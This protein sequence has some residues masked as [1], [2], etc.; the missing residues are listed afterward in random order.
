[1]ENLDLYSLP[2]KYRPKDF[3]EF[4]GNDT[5][6]NNLRDILSRE[7][8]I[9]HAFLFTGP[10]GCGKTTLALIVKEKL[11]CHDYDYTFLNTSNTR[12]I[13]TI[14][15]ISSTMAY[16]PARG[17]TKFYLL[18]ECHK[19]TNEAQNALLNALEHPPYFCYFALCTTNPEK[20][21]PTIKNRCQIFTVKSLPSPQIMKLL[22][23]VCEKEKVDFPANIL[24][25]IAKS[26]AGSC[27]GALKLL[28]QV[29]D[30]EDDEEVLKSIQNAVV[31][32]AS[33]LNICQLLV[34]E[35]KDKWPQMTKFIDAI[36][37]DEQES[38]RIGIINY[39]TKVLLGKRGNDRIAEMLSIFLE[40]TYDTGKKGGI[41]YQLYLA[42][43][44]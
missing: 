21:L 38:A 39:L 28:D 10:S 22:N 42:C 14:R 7:K 35:S 15:E 36:E 31:S 2:V 1:M 32:E 33:L 23:S 19:L 5:L 40:N 4:V 8:G 41:T 3:E 37:E 24:R 11:E 13:D 29:I 17:K 20:L 43:K 9:P 18:D 44:L 25:E 16:K 27:R 26:S 30:I 34:E 6:V 12:G